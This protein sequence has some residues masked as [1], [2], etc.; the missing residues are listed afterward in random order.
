M[1][2]AEAFAPAKINLTL[3]VTGQRADG[4]HLLDSLVVF[5]DIGDRIDV[6]PAPRTR[7]TTSGPMADGVPLDRRNL[8]LRAAELLGVTADIRLEKNLPAAAGLG[9]GSSD[10]AATL[11]ALAD[12][13]G[14]T[15]PGAGQML[16]LGADVPLCSCRGPTRMRGIGEVLEPVPV[17]A[18]LLLVLANPRQPVATGPVFQ[19]LQHKNGT[20][21]QS[22]PDPGGADWLAWLAAQR[23]DLES[24]AIALQ[25]VIGQVLE[26]LRG[27]EGCQLA[28]MS[29]SG[30]TCFA[31]MRN[32][33]AQDGAVARL[34]RA[35]P[36]WWVKSC[37]LYER[38]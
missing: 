15:M 8:V 7:L 22:P 9:G 27:L 19:A 32:E 38:G 31:I 33:T 18:R 17:P 37:G 30:A 6:S 12:M 10:A 36:H 25:P 34:R 21:M 4:L 3:H 20:P 16:T 14:R 35:F 2:V 24:P 5:G 13:T 11:R 23:N 26:V 1:T 29:G 28:R